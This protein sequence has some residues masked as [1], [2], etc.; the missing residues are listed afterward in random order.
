[1]KHHVLLLSAALCCAC[2]DG[3]ETTDDTVE[4][5]RALQNSVDEIIVP[6]MGD[7]VTTVDTLSTNVTAFCAAPSE[8]GLS[9]LQNDWRAM[10]TAWNRAALYNVGPLNQDLIFPRVIFI[11]SMRQRGIDYTSTVR[12]AIDAALADS[13]AL[14]AAFFDA[15]LFTESGILSLE[16]QL[17]ESASDS[18]TVV[19]DVAAEFQSSPRQCDYLAGTADR[20]RRVAGDALAG[21]TTNYLETG[22]SFRDVMV[23]DGRLEDGTESVPALV[24]TAF[25]HLEYVKRRKLEGILD[26]QLADHFYENLVSSLDELSSLLDSPSY[27]F[28]DHM[29]ARGFSAEVTDAQA[30]IAS[31]RS[32]AI[33]EDRAAVT[34]AWGIVEGFLKREIPNGLNVDLGINFSDG[35]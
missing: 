2:G 11:E 21:W 9:G 33:A 30:A 18:S 24:V 15:Q 23:V 22:T 27:G 6:T 8:S 13:A 5:Q 7:F 28:F 17:F 32:A 4:L 25:D 34:A 1:M 20:L 29:T 14:D 19:G 12:E 35:D 10:V 16:V 3:E 31:A 26:A